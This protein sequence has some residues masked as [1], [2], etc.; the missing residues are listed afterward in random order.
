MRSAERNAV[1]HIVD[2]DAGVRRSLLRLFESAGFQ[3]RTYATPF[4]LLE[5][6][7]GL[8]AGCILLDV[9]MPGMDGLEVQARLHDLG[10]ALPIIVMTAQGDVQTA[11]SAMKAGAVDFIEKPAGDERLLKATEEALVA[12][13]PADGDGKAKEAARQ[14]ASLSRREG[15]VL[16]LLARGLSHKEI[17]YELQISV[18]T[19]EVHRARMLRRLG[20]RRLAEAIRMAVLS[21]E[22]T[23]G[24]PHSRPAAQDGA[25][26]P[27]ST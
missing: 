22:A 1:I 18:R 21:E 5:A 6:V 20:T 12:A 19:V 13:A 27:P 14:L 2:D 16:S 17:A 24:G 3:A 23:A 10:V 25:A 8:A 11:V 7:D 9:R 15:E 26:D 4:A